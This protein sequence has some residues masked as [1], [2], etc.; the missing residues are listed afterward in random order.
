M[1]DI[2]NS[3]ADGSPRTVA[4]QKRARDAI[5]LADASQENKKV[6]LTAPSDDAWELSR[7]FICPINRGLPIE[8]VTAEDGKVY[9]RADIER[10]FET[11]EGDPT[12]PMTGAVIGTELIPAPQIRK[13]IEAHV[14][15]GAIKGKI[16][17]AWKR[18]LADETKVK[19]T[20][21]K[22]EGGDG[23]A[24][25]LLG[26]W[27]EA[28]TRGLAK[29][30]A[31]ARAWYERS[32][33][34]SYPKGLAKFGTCLLRGFG[35]PQ[36][37]KLGLENVTEAA[38]LGSDRGAALLGM[39]FFHG[40]FGLPKDGGQARYWLRKVADGECEYKEVT[41]EGRAEAAGFLRE[42]VREES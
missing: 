21:A 30:A 25:D 35:G 39:C 41:D 29:D 7:E 36:D 42:L 27:Y 32:A 12:S 22:A 15:S 28:G 33:A 3:D 24:M 1:K 11:K 37:K 4:A 40:A 34:A 14:E 38:G 5:E 17:E 19:E 23:E 8:P 2:T 31:Q 16:A 13:A 18:K 9:E 20:R 6:A 26:L 10:W